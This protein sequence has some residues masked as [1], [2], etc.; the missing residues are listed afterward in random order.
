MIKLKTIGRLLNILLKLTKPVNDI[1]DFSKIEKMSYSDKSIYFWC[2][3][4]VWRD[5]ISAEIRAK[6]KGLNLNFQT[7]S[8]FL[9]FGD[10][11][12][13]LKCGGRR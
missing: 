13:F 11:M 7:W 5:E 12:G 1:L 8:T 4:T 2:N 9:L 3:K 6:E 10:E